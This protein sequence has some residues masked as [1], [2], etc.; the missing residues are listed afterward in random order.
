MEIRLERVSDKAVSAQQEQFSLMF[1]GPPEMFIPQGM[2]SLKNNTLGTF[3]LFLVPIGK[4][5]NGFSYEAVFNLLRRQ[6]S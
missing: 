3:D 4:D 5:E 6:S 1:H 2:Y